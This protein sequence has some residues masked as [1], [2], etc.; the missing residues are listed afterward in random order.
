MESI[1]ILAGVGV[2]AYFAYS[3]GWFSSLVPVVTPVIPPPPSPSQGPGSTGNPI[4]NPATVIVNVPPPAPPPP[5]AIDEGLRNTIWA[6][7]TAR[8]NAGW[9]TAD[10]AQSFYNQVV[11]ATSQSDLDNITQQIA[12]YVAGNQSNAAA[13]VSGLSTGRS[14]YQNLLHYGRGRYYPR[15][16]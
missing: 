6:G 14:T 13:G 16:V 4:P 5:V 1:L 15:M 9:L 7:I 12:L 8:L 11:A 3:Q 10:Q 2:A